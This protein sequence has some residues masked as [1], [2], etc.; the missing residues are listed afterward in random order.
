MKYLARKSI[1]DATQGDKV[2]FLVDINDCK[3]GTKGTV[4]SVGLGHI[5]VEI[6]PKNAYEQENASLRTVVTVLADQVPLLAFEGE[7]PTTCCLQA[8]AA[9][10]APAAPVE[11]KKD[12]EVEEK[13]DDE[14]EE[15]NDDDAVDSE[16][17]QGGAENTE[18]G[19]NLG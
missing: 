17:T 5:S 13:D 8:A 10:E 14:Q 19:E 9:P 4:T 7:M 6:E 15:G 11:E 1:K 18:G 16:K 12:D 2:M 3:P